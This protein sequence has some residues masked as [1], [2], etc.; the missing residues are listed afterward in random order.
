MWVWGGGSPRKSPVK[1]R[2]KKVDGEA[3]VEDEAPRIGL[4]VIVGGGG[5][6]PVAAGIGRPDGMGIGVGEDGWI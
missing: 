6:I 2:K 4:D 1:I 5:A 3:G